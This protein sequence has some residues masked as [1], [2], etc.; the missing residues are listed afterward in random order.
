[1]GTA[2]PCRHHVGTQC[3]PPWRAAAQHSTAQH[4]TAQH[5]TAQ[6]S[7]A[8]HMTAQQAQCSTAATVE[9]TNNNTIKRQSYIMAQGLWTGR[10]GTIASQ[11]RCGIM[12]AA[13]NLAV[14][15]PASNPHLQSQIPSP[16]PHVTP[17]PT[18]R[19]RFCAIMKSTKMDTSHSSLSCR[20]KASSRRS[21][22]WYSV[23]VL[24]RLPTFSLTSA[25]C[26]YLLSKQ[27]HA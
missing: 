11:T 25:R 10:N 15:L 23:S 27:S 1:M 19:H 24:T 26:P 8:Q 17:L 21:V 12:Q 13:A 7:T 9:Q 2:H 4:S 14:S 18:W 6:H 22:C 20:A 16:S 5:S 3:K